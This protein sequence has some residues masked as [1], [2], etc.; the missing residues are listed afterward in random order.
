MRMV[1]SSSHGES[2]DQGCFVCVGPDRSGI[3]E[4]FLPPYPASFKA[5]LHDPVEEAPEDLKTVA[6]ADAGEAGMVGQWLVK[7]LS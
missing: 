1:R 7:I 5:H 3:H 6:F 4:Q 2:G